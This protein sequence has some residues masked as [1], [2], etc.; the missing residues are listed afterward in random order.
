M[1]NFRKDQYVEERRAN[2]YYPWASRQ[3]WD[4]TLWL[5][6]SGLSMAAVSSL[7][8]LEIVSDCT[9]VCLTF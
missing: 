2:L 1:D 7:L 9:F 3:A 6:C 8:L 4:V 5:L